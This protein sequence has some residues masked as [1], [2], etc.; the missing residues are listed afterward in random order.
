V[1]W[2]RRLSREIPFLLGTLVLGKEGARIA[3]VASGTGMHAIALAGEGFDVKGFDPDPVLLGEAAR[4]AA[5]SAGRGGRPLSVEWAAASFATLPE[6]ASPKSF[7][8]VFCLGNSIALIPGSELSSAL[9]NMALLLGMGGR[10]VAHTINFPNLA[11]RG[12]EPWGPVRRLEDGTLLLKG[13]VPRGLDPWDVIFI[14][15]EPQEGAAPPV[16]TVSRFQVHPH[17]S[18]EVV[19][20]AESAGLVLRERHGGF[21]GEEP[22]DFRSADLVYLFERS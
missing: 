7:E 16:R 17:T 4:R 18:E 21:A 2:D 12:D 10:L 20:A 8:A 11:R 5:E 19:A 3:D 13:F 6:A 1:D 9:A 15:L 22:D 14:S